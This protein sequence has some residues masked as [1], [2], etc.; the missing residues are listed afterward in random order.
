VDLSIRGTRSHG[1]KV[2]KCWFACLDLYSNYMLLFGLSGVT[3]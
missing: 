3:V 1:G 2:G